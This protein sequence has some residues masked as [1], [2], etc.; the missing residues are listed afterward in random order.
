MQAG[1][2]GA[3]STIAQ[4]FRLVEPLGEGG[5]GAVWR[6]DHLVL[7][8]AVAVKLLRPG[9]LVGEAADDKAR[10]RF[11]IEAQAAARLRSPHVVQV[12]DHGFED[13]VPYIVMELLEGESLGRRIRRERTL[14]LLRT[15]RVVTQIARALAR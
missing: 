1:A 3:G 2:L 9:S 7:G 15:E 10:R 14:D 11:S 4:R 8:S 6:A 13:G 5:M 12:L